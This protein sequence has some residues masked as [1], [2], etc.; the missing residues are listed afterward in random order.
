MYKCVKAFTIGYKYLNVYKVCTN[1][2]KYLKI[3][4]NVYKHSQMCTSILKCIQVCTKVYKYLKMCTSIHK[5]AQMCKST[6][7]CVQVYTSV[8]KCTHTCIWHVCWT[9]CTETGH[10]F[11]DIMSTCVTVTTLHFHIHISPWTNNTRDIRTVYSVHYSTVKNHVTPTNAL[12]YNL[13]S[14]SFT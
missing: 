9:Y 2:Y 1:V 14:Q 11:L 4:T 3:C 6:C 12:F 10:M 13:C 8:Y 5:C 7:N